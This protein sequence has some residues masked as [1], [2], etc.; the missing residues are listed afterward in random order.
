MSQCT[1]FHAAGG[2]IDF[3][4]FFFYDTWCVAVAISQLLQ[5]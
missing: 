3:A 1:K 4:M 5:E 2:L